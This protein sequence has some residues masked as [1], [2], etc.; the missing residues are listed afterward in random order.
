MEARTDYRT[1]P[2]TVRIEETIGSVETTPLPEPVS[3]L[4]FDPHWGVSR[5][6]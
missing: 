1:L 4:D 2:P 5:D 3:P 6:Y